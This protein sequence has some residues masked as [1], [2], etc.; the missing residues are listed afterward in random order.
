MKPYFACLAIALTLT[1]AYFSGGEADGKQVPPNGAAKQRK[2]VKTDQEWLKQL[3]QDQFLVT[4]RKVTEPPF[5]GQYV[6]VKG[7]GV[8][9]CVCCGAELFNTAAKFDSGTG[10]PSFFRP[11]AANRVDRQMDYSDGS[12]RIEVV[13][14]ECGAHLGHVFDDGPA[15]TGL[16]FCINSLS[17]KYVPDAKT[18]AASTSKKMKGKTAK[19]TKVAKNTAGKNAK[20]N[21]T[22]KTTKQS[23]AAAK[24][25]P[26]ADSESAKAE[27]AK[28]DA[29]KSDSAAADDDTND[30]P[31]PQAKAKKTTKPQSD[32]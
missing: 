19:N 15:P 12:P 20:S 24:D 30:K 31:A 9:E 3:T 22:A 18:K 13:C 11:I 25:D 2:V 16:R 5:S 23:D 10:W 32:D 17:L 21:A 14:N 4:R 28:A 29:G 7:K 27:S 26:A 8:F 6:H 1:L